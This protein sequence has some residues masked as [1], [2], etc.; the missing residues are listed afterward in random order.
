MSDEQKPGFGEDQSKDQ[1]PSD[2]KPAEDKPGLPAD[3]KAGD[4]GDTETPAEESGSEGDDETSAGED[5]QDVFRAGAGAIA[6]TEGESW[7]YVDPDIEMYG[8]F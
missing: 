1:K 8:R 7:L 2:E 3:D 5:E 6:R 4:K